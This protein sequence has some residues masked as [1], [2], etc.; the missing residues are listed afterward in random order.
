M[1]PNEISFDVTRAEA[2]TIAKLARRAKAMETE[3]GADLDTVK[4]R[5]IM[6]WSMDFTATHANGCPLRL[7]ALLEADDFNFMHDAFGIA[8]HIDRET[9][10]LGNCFL[11]RYAAPAPSDAA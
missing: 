1:A 5:S 9:G 3:H 2:A 8:R 4:P 6:D 10:K 11:P 7:E